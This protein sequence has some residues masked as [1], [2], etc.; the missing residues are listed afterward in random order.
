MR[1]FRVVF[2]KLTRCDLSG[3]QLPGAVFK[4]AT[5]TNCTLSKTQLP[6]AAFDCAT[7]MG[8]SNDGKSD[9]RGVN[10]QAAQFPCATVKYCDFSKAEDGTRADMKNTH[11]ASSTITYNNINDVDFTGSNYD[12]EFWSTFYPHL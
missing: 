2:I 1:V 6:G 7:V 8:N 12:H 9:C 11:F 4:S 5:L 10:M 3:A